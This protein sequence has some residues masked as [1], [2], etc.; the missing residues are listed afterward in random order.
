MANYPVRH[1]DFGTGDTYDINIERYLITLKV[2]N[3]KAF[4]FLLGTNYSSTN[5]EVTEIK[6]LNT[7]TV[8]S[9]ID[10][11]T[12]IEHSI[13]YVKVTGQIGFNPTPLV[14]QR[15]S[16]GNYFYQFTA[17]NQMYFMIGS[18]TKT[19]V[20]S[21]AYL[22]VNDLNN[23]HEYAYTVNSAVT[24]IANSP[25]GVTRVWFA[26]KDIIPVLYRAISSSNYERYIASAY[27]ITDASNNVQANLETFLSNNI[28]DTTSTWYINYEYIVPNVGTVK[29]KQ[30]FQN[31]ENAQIKVTGNS[32]LTVIP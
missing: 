14:I 32:T 7:N 5:F 12:I 30:A 23:K 28:S 29:I 11:D 1:L 9:S 6:N 22:Y 4:Q 21:I 26:N 19:G 31:Q 24:S 3:I 8:L 15:T 17:I 2:Q 25:S 18:F 16:Q 27:Y 20:P 10:L 13:V